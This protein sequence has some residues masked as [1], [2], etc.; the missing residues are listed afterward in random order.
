MS[1]SP[2]EDYRRP[3]PVDY[4]SKVLTCRSFQ[5]FELKDQAVNG[6]GKAC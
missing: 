6:T 1:G 3:M 2:F 5:A 4:R